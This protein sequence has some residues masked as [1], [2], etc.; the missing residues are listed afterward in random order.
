MSKAL[1]PQKKEP[2]EVEII[3]RIKDLIL[4][5]YA[6]NKIADMFNKQKLPSPRNGEWTA[7]TVRRIAENP[8]YAGV[9]VRGKTRRRNNPLCEADFSYEQPPEL[10]ELYDDP[11]NHYK[12]FDKDEW[13][14]LQ[15]R[16]HKIKEKSGKRGRPAA[17]YGPSIL[18]GR[19]YC[20]YCRAVLVNGGGKGGRC[21]RCKNRRKHKGNPLRCEHSFTVREDQFVPVLA[22]ICIEVIRPIFDDCLK[23]INQELFKIGTDIRKDIK[24]LEKKRIL[25][26]ERKETIIKMTN[27]ARLLGYGDKFT[28]YVEEAVN[29]EDKIHRI[30]IDLKNFRDANSIAMEPLAVDKKLFDEEL[31]NLHKLFQCEKGVTALK[32]ALDKFLPKIYIKSKEADKEHYILYLRI[33]ELPEG[34]NDFIKD[35]HVYIINRK[36][37]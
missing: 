15:I 32:T 27:E 25:L 14:K 21:F 26:L 12:I 4:T 33:D 8:I 22:H 5:G 10:W 19:L 31:N 2:I 23:V 18:S 6:Y 7:T 16:I 24:E 36:K 30:D 29:L 37:N 17:E 3:V 20:W 28:S 9:L 11:D 35:E 13:I 34:F 1:G